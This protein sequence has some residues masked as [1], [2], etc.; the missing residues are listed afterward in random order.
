MLQDAG[1]ARAVAALDCLPPLC[2]AGRHGL[3]VGNRE[4][5]A[6]AVILPETERVRVPNESQCNSPPIRSGPLPVPRPAERE[7]H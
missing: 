3:V 1:L 4:I 7:T 2:P 6:T 5:A